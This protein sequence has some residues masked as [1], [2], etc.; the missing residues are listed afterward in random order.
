MPTA[1]SI[2]Q[3]FYPSVT[4]VVDATEHMKV[5]VTKRD[6]ESRAVKNHQE[7]AL[8]IACKRSLQV[9][10]VIIAIRAAY[11]VDGKK[12]YRYGL[13]ESIAREVTAFDRNG[14]FEPGEYQLLKPSHRIGDQRSSGSRTYTKSNG[15]GKGKGK[16]RHIT[17]DIRDIYAN[18]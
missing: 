3:R 5:K 18:S 15:K 14:R 4:T 7:C 10:G 2:V 1:L 11:L 8:A 17:T 6:C 13:G 9:N 16:Y 12:A